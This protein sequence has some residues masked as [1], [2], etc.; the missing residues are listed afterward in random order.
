[1]AMHRAAIQEN[2]IALAIEQCVPI[3]V[4]VRHRLATS[5][6]QRSNFLRNNFRRGRRSDPWLRP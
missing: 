2:L 3:P 4:K 5:N 6:L 1:L